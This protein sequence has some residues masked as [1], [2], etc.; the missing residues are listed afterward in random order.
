MFTRTM[1]ARAKNALKCIQTAQ[2]IGARRMRCYTACGHL[3]KHV[4]EASTCAAAAWPSGQKKWEPRAALGCVMPWSVAFEHS[5]KRAGHWRQTQ[6]RIALAHV[7]HGGNR[8]VDIF[9][10]Q[11]VGRCDCGSAGGRWILH[12]CRV[13]DSTR[14][15]SSR[16]R[17]VA[18][19]CQTRFL[20]SRDDGET[21]RRARR[22]RLR[23]VPYCEHE[24]RQLGV[25]EL[26]PQVRWRTSEVDPGSGLCC[27][28]A[29]PS[30]S[31]KGGC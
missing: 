24:V 6:R 17:R 23:H 31:S 20:E 27:I 21:A 2:A 30:S 15:L 1:L 14:T 9:T 22:S 10:R 26:P 28:I 16:G 12:Y 5:K 18:W 25:L 19:G 29:A 13:P 11:T 3:R 8:K 7:R 4:E